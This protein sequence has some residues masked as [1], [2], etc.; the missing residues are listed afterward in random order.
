MLVAL[1]RAMCAWIETISV[2]L[3]VPELVSRP[4]RGVLRILARRL[5]RTKY[6]LWR[7]CDELHLIEDA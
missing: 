1:I 2:Q 7:A 6:G 5:E 4:A 3:H